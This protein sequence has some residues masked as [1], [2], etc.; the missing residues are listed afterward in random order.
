MSAHYVV[1]SLTPP[2]VYHLEF[3]YFTLIGDGVTQSKSN[4]KTNEAKM[5]KT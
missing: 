5:H 2:L 3:H 4:K 1:D